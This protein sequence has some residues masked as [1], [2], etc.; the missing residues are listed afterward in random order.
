VVHALQQLFELVQ[1]PK[2]RDPKEL[3]HSK[4]DPDKVEPEGFVI[5]VK[6]GLPS[7]ALVISPFGVVLA[8]KRR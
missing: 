8:R 4:G 2:E 5:D 7:L 1:D 3:D 6:G